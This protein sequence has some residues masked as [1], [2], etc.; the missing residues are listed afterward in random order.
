[1]K[2]I[3][4][5]AELDT[6]L[7]VAKNGDSFQLW[8]VEKAGIRPATPEDG[9]AAECVLRKLA[10]LA[11]GARAPFGLPES[12]RT[13]RGRSALQ[14]VDTKER[15]LTPPELEERLQKS[16]A[17]TMSDL[18][19]Q[20]A[21]PLG[22]IP[23][24]GAGMSV[25][26]KFAAWR[27]FL[28][29][30]APSTALRKRVEKLLD[31]G[32]YEGAAEALKR[33]NEDAFQRRIDS[34]FC[35]TLDR[36]QLEASALSSLPLLT[37][38]PVITTNFDHVLEQVF[39]AAGRDFEKII[40]GSSPDPVVAAIQR[41]DHVLF[42]IHGDCSDS[43]TRTFTLGEYETSY[44]A[45]P[46]K[47]RRAS[48]RSLLELLFS[49]RPLLILGASLETDRTMEILETL[50]RRHA[51]LRHYAVLGAYYRRRKLEKR[52]EQ[53]ASL[54]IT[55]LWYAPKAFG[56]IGEILREMVERVSTEELG[57][58]PTRAAPPALSP[59]V[60]SKVRSVGV[61]PAKPKKAPDPHIQD[62]A[63]A[64]RD[65][66]VIFFLGSAVNL[67]NLPTGSQFYEKLTQR[68]PVPAFP[69]HRSDGAQLLEDTQGREALTRAVRS[70]LGEYNP[71]PT[72]IHQFIA[73]L[74][75]TLRARN[76][77]NTRQVIFTTNYDTVLESTFDECGEP[78]HLLMY[79]SGERPEGR[80]IHRDPKGHLRALVKPE[81]IRELEPTGAS[82]IVKL[83][84]SV[85]PLGSV[86]AGINVTMKDF[87]VLAERIPEILPTVLRR[88]IA[89]RSFLFLGHGLN[90]LHVEKLVRYACELRKSGSW[91]VLKLRGDRAAVKALREYWRPCH[92]ELRNAELESYVA[93]LK[94]AV[95]A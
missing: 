87:V 71:R 80:F 58:L 31:G 46:G 57:I 38:G 83:D 54:G 14:A 50:Y 11:P 29:D 47:K 5:E 93:A 45:P 91:A 32:D 26:F 25:P 41:N 33:T 16:N 77:K 13:A 40:L 2:S 9:E 53:L 42:K 70:I 81:N 6:V 60:P 24:V 59:T 69:R 37:M 48:L 82:I 86:P 61:K 65:G 19:R 74:P 8:A 95:H 63:T 1:M 84:G 62:V 68:L 34:E 52:Q 79:Q 43:K 7:F 3:A 56:R 75:E 20:L 85:E 94:R 4:E 90:E 72:A 78:Y 66:S 30:A 76:V 28:L 73:G 35:R 21:S 22:V 67:D 23:F 55:P 15:I 64:I 36:N 89:R 44:G 12:P 92:L 17:G 49:N 39:T 27:D 18:V 88:E 10:L 51:A